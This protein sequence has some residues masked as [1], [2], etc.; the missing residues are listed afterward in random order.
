MKERKPRPGSK[1]M[2]K[3]LSTARGSALLFDMYSDNED[4]AVSRQEILSILSFQ[5][6]ISNTDVVNL[7]QDFVVFG[8]VEKEKYKDLDSQFS[9]L[10]KKWAEF[11]RLDPK[12][13][14]WKFYDREVLKKIFQR[15]EG[16]GLM[17]KILSFMN[18]GVKEADIDEV[19][20][21]SCKEIFRTALEAEARGMGIYARQIFRAPVFWKL[22]E[23]ELMEL[24]ELGIAKNIMPNLFVPMIRS[25]L[26]E[27]SS[28]IHMAERRKTFDKALSLLLRT[29]AGEKSPDLITRVFDVLD[30][31]DMNAPG[32]VEAYREL[33]KSLLENDKSG[34]IVSVLE[35]ASRKDQTAREFSQKALPRLFEIDPSGGS[36]LSIYKES[37]RWSDSE[38]I[39]PG[40]EPHLM[41]DEGFLHTV[42]ELL[43]AVKKD[44]IELVD[45]ISNWCVFPREWK[46]SFLK[47][48]LQDNDEV[49]AEKD[50]WGFSSLLQILLYDQKDE[51]PR[52]RAIER[53]VKACEKELHFGISFNSRLA[54]ICSRVLITQLFPNIEVFL[55]VVTEVMDCHYGR[56]GKEGQ[57]LL[58]LHN[59]V[60]PFLLTL[61]TDSLRESPL[62]TSL[63]IHTKF[64]ERCGFESFGTDK[65]TDR[66]KKEYL[67]LVGTILSEQEAEP[68]RECFSGGLAI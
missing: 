10:V 52:Q 27:R 31:V 35:W 47:C 58:P 32:R 7:L 42:R 23:K 17:E 20:D 57:T 65:G 67:K 41:W 59:N 26:M 68:D 37:G 43:L 11:P 46:A 50:E 54:E 44:Q 25:L 24:L 64:L 8:T 63:L 38:E 21:K 22:P 13:S 66:L 19:K 56:L 40:D 16:H 39:E 34:N 45:E 6:F 36:I 49:I 2:L 9:G 1:E 18:E 53:I 3:L 51:K 4:A 61:M 5:D 30:S 28:S 62:K 12:L 29:V 60:C 14:P 33:Y 55:E 48:F 15:Y